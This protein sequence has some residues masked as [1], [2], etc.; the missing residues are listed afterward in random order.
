MHDFTVDKNKFK[1][2]LQLQLQKQGHQANKPLITLLISL[3][4]LNTHQ[5][6]AEYTSPHGATLGLEVRTKPSHWLSSG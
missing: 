4:A 5:N 3:I 2:K 6:Q 1:K